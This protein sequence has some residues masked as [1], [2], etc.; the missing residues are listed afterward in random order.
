M[1]MA[2]LG[3]GA[4]LA[5]GIGAWLLVGHAGGFRFGAAAESPAQSALVLAQQKCV[6]NSPY[7][8]IGDAGATLILQSQGDEQRGITYAQLDCF[9]RQ[10]KVTDAIKSE[11][12]TTRA[13]DGRQSAQWGPFSAFWSYHPDDGLR[14]TITLRS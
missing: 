4:L 6:S 7:A 9:W 11:I 8:T 5:C 14:M 3:G 2:G 10:L 12:E 1:L 13:L